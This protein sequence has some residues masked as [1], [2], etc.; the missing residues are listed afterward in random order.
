MTTETMT[1]HKALTEL[2]LIDNR[3]KKTIEEGI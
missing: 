2:K 1:V 3:I